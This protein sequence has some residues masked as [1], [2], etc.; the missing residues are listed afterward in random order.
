LPFLAAISPFALP[1][2]RIVRQFAI[3]GEQRF[4]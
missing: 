4:Q 2:R 3:P 1:V